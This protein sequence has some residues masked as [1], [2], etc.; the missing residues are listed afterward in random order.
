M[1]ATLS[2]P[3]LGQFMGKETTMTNHP[4]RNIKYSQRLWMDGEYTIGQVGFLICTSPQQRE[5]SYNLALRPACKNQSC[6]R[7]IYGWCGSWNNTST[8]GAGIAIVLRGCANGRVQVGV[9]TA[10][11][12]GVLGIADES[13]REPLKKFLEE[14]G[15]SDEFDDFSDCPVF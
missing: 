12:N 15:W 6:E 8:S 14:N 2:N 11:K 1:V 4:N 5:D 3:R 9:I 7:V 13:H 10:I